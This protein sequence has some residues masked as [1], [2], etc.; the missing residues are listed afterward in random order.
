MRP[1]EHTKENNKLLLMRKTKKKSHQ[2]TKIKYDMPMCDA[3]W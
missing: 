2:E 3:Y 1:S